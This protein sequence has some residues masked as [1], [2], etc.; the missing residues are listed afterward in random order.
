MVFLMEKRNQAQKIR[1]FRATFKTHTT[2]T[3]KNEFTNKNY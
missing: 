1:Y 3:L 2:H